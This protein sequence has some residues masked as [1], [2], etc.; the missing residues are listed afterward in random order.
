MQHETLRLYAPVV[1]HPRHTG[2]CH[3]SLTIQGKEYNVP[4]KTVILLNAVALST[5]PE[6]WGPDSLT[7]RPNRWIM[8]DANQ[9]E[10]LFQPRDGVY[11]PFASGPRICPARKFAQV[12]FVAVMARLFRENR[13]EPVLLAGESM[14]EARRRVKEVVD[15]S[16]VMNTLK[17]LDPD[18]VKLRWVRV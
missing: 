5:L 2:D 1:A 15:D 8:H 11:T 18:K 17:M 6:Y 13:C 16:N 3:Q 4:P 9:E 10:S 7:W 14:E 12:E